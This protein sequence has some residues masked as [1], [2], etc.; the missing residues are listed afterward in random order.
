MVAV[1]EELLRGSGVGLHPATANAVGVRPGQRKSFAGDHGGI[2][3]VWKLSTTRGAAVSSLRSHAHAA[4]AVLGDLLVLSFHLD[5]GGGDRV[6]VTGIGSGVTG[7]DRLQM[8]LGH[9]VRSID[10]VAEA[11]ECEPGEVEEVLRRR[12]DGALAD[13]VVSARWGKQAR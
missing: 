10:D 4:A 13:D 8:V 12:G 1:D 9:R 3:V 5:D 2:V 6:E 11:L 7:I